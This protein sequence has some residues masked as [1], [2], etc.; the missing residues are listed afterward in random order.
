MY[1]TVEATYESGVLKLHQPLPL[2]EHETVRISVDTGKDG[3]TGSGDVIAAHGP[4][5]TP[6]APTDPACGSSAPAAEL[7]HFAESD[8]VNIWLDMPP[9]STARTVVP[10]RA[11]PILPGPLQV[12]EFDL[13]PE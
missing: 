12:E 11:E 1:I 10:T 4:S 9:S 8:M 2:E 6:A 13:A 3:L 7:S 5:R